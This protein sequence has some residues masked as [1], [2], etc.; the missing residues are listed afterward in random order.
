MD[1]PEYETGYLELLSFFTPIYKNHTKIFQ[2]EDIQ[3]LVNCSPFNKFV[4]NN[5]SEYEKK[6]KDS[7]VLS[8]VFLMLSFSY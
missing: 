6:T 8:Y 1:H 7:I 4:E 2:Q 3:E 5:F